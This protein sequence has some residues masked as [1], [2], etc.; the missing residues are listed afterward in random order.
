MTKLSTDIL[1]TLHSHSNGDKGF[2][3]ICIHF[4]FR[5]CWSWQHVP[6]QTQIEGTWQS[7]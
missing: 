2:S 1:R 6:K 3:K 5:K 7:A 4:T